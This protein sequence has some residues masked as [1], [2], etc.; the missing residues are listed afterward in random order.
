MMPSIISID[1]AWIIAL[2]DKRLA[3]H[4]LIKKPEC[5]HKSDGNVY[6]SN[7]PQNKCIKCGELYR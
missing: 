6:T 5:E 4:G 7:P 3:E 1:E 2:I